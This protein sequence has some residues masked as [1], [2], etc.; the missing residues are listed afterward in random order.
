M[1][2]SIFSDLH[3]CP[4]IFIG[5][6][7]DRLDAILR[8][9][10]EENVQFIIHAGDFCH[11]PGREDAAPYVKKYNEFHIPTYHCLGNHDTDGTPY[12]ETLKLY[13]MPDGHYFFDADGF[14]MI[15]CNP[16]F[17]LLDGE[18]V[19]YDLGNYYKHGPLRD[20][21]PPEQLTWLRETIESSPHPCVI[22]S[23]ESFERGNGGVKNMDAVQ[24]I[25]NDANR[26]KPHSVILCINGH[27]H[28]DHIR[29]L[30]NV[31]YFELNAASYHYLIKEHTLYPENL[32]A[33][34]RRINHTL[35][36]EDPIH[37]VIT[38]EEKDGAVSIAIDGMESRTLFGIP[39]EMTGNDRY[40]SCGRE[41]LARVQ[42]AKIVLAD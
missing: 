1:K 34:Y 22:I 2:F 14:R 25:I 36:Y 9:A 21:M 40:D 24:R 33:E 8:R 4:G 35:V 13:N 42:S 6:D 37:A 26:R 17:Y 16:N 10:E 31:V 27:H 5:G 32:V 41:A 15:I 29:I 38:L 19:H 28:C 30:D 12:E 23:H 3:C 39:K 20:H 11:A 18:Y 7:K